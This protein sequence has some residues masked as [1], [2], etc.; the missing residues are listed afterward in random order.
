MGAGTLGELMMRSPD[1]EY[2]QRREI[3]ERAA[4]DR[5]EPS[6]RR[7]HLDLADLYAARS[8]ENEIDRLASTS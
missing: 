7:A 2:Y 8:R 1:A 4:A 3:E 6:A 5:A